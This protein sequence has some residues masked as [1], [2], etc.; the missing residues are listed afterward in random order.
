MSTVVSNDIVA[1]A[2]QVAAEF[3]DRQW[4]RGYDAVDDAGQLAAILPPELTCQT[5]EKSEITPLLNP[6]VAW[7]LN[8]RLQVGVWTALREN[9]PNVRLAQ[10]AGEASLILAQAQAVVRA[11]LKQHT[12]G[13]PREVTEAGLAVWNDYIATGPE[14]VREVLHISEARARQADQD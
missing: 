10:R 3:D 4:S 6:P 7:C 2:L 13:A 1:R 12:R 9:D 8:G 11:A 5:R 14:E